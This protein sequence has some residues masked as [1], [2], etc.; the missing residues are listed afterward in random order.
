MHQ[1]MER[2]STTS[3]SEFATFRETQPELFRE[4]GYQTLD[5]TRRLDSVLACAGG[6]A[7][8]QLLGLGG[9]KKPLHR[10][11]PIRSFFGQP[12]KLIFTSTT[13]GGLTWGHEVWRNK[14]AIPSNE[15]EAIKAVQSG[16]NH[17]FNNVNNTVYSCFL[18]SFNRFI[19]RSHFLLGV[20]CE[21]KSA[22]L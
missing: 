6:Y 20:G 18:P 14:S 19:C 21:S 4:L 15:S 9:C 10:Q 22:L 3:P 1:E 12:E 17:P 7:G 13:T 11:S 16:A 8:A 2:H 5:A